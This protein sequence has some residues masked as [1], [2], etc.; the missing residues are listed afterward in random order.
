MISRS[1]LGLTH[2]W[3]DDERLELREAGITT[4]IIVD[5]KLV[6]PLGQA[7]AGTPCAWDVMS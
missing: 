3:D 1:G 7:V 4:A 5:G 6:A 2:E